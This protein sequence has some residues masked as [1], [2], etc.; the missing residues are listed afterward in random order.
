MYIVFV[1]LDVVYVKSNEKSGFRG[2]DG[3]PMWHSRTPKVRKRGSK[4]DNA[5]TLPHWQ[6][7]AQIRRDNAMQAVGEPW[8]PVRAHSIT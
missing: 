2:S 1:K 6:A 8:N 7:T 4:D 5:E 3:S